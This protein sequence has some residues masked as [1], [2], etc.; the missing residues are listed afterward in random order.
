MYWQAKPTEQQRSST[1]D[2]SQCLPPLG[3]TVTKQQQG[4]QRD[5]NAQELVWVCGA[6]R[7]S[8]LLRVTHLLIVHRT[9]NLQSAELTSD[10]AWDRF[11]ASA[12]VVEEGEDC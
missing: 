9:N 11:S 7:G 4:E 6:E 1:R 2:N 12:G 5:E 3:Q 8:I 10:E